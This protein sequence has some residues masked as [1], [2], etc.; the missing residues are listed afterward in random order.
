MCIGI[1]SFSL[2]TV[3]IL[4]P[5]TAIFLA[6]PKDALRGRRLADDDELKH[7]VREGLRRHSEQF[8]AT[9]IERLTQT[10]GKK[11]LTLE[12][13]LWKNNVS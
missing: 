7:T 6:P 9:R 3:A 2:P 8:D 4:K 12:M 1:F 13:S 10:W 5:P 11:Y